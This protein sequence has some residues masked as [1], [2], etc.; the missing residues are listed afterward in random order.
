M[1]YI[2]V[3]LKVQENSCFYTR[4]WGESTCIRSLSKWSEIFISVAW[5]L[6]IKFKQKSKN[7]WNIY[8]L[9]FWSVFFLPTWHS[10]KNVFSQ[11]QKLLFCYNC[12]GSLNFSYCS[13]LTWEFTSI[14]FQPHSNSAIP[15][16]LQCLLPKCCRHETENKEENRWIKVHFKSPSLKTEGWKIIGYFFHK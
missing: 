11:C 15:N 14:Y 16:I 3:V 5:F 8:F 2:I 6:I 4:L 10:E 13:Y 12:V 9:K 7:I 1:V